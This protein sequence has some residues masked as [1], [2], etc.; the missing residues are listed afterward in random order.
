[1][2]AVCSG[3]PVETKVVSITLMSPLQ[4][5]NKLVVEAANGWELNSIGSNYAFLQRMPG[6]PFADVAYYVESITL[7][8]P[9]QIKSALCSFGADGWAVGG[10]GSNF[11]FYK[12]G[13]N[14]PLVAREYD[15]ESVT[16][17]GIRS[18]KRLL[19]KRSDTGWALC[20]MGRNFAFFERVRD[21]DGKPIEWEHKSVASK[22]VSITLKTPQQLQEA[23]EREGA[24]GWHICGIGASYM[25]LRKVRESGGT[26]S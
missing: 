8:L 12:R 20:A 21:K 10:V 22:L 11:A 14:Q 13:R 7:S 16:L 6:A 25:F 26:Q 18:I 15:M 2:L 9:H 17:R 1:M 4:I 23:L 3:S 19:E 24:E 5:K